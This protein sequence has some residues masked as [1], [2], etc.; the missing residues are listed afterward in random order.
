MNIK[1]FLTNNNISYIPIYYKIENGRKKPLFDKSN[2]TME[3][4]NNIDKKHFNKDG[5]IKAWSIFIK[6]TPDLY[7]IDIDDEYVNNIQD[8]NDVDAPYIDNE[9]YEKIKNTIWIKGNTKGIHIYLYITKMPIFSTY[10]NV[11]DGFKGDLIRT[12]N[13]WEQIDKDVNNDKI[14][15][16][17]FNDIEYLFNDRFY[18]S[19]KKQEKYD[20]EDDEDME[21]IEDDEDDELFEINDNMTLSEKIIIK[22]IENNFF[23]TL[24]GYQD[25]LKVCFI[26]SSEL[27][28]N[29]Y[30]YFNYISK[31]QLDSDKYNEASVKSQ[32]DISLNRNDLKNKL[33]I[34]TLIKMVNSLNNEKLKSE[35]KALRLIENKKIKMQQNNLNFENENDD[36]YLDRIEQI[37][38][39]EDYYKIFKI[40]YFDEFKTYEEKKIYFEIFVCKIEDPLTFYKREIIDNKLFENYI[41]ISN[42]KMTFNNLL[43]KM[44]VKDK[45]K[46]ESFINRWTQDPKM[47]TYKQ[48]IFKPFNGIRRLDI[49]DNPKYFNNTFNGYN[50]LIHYDYDKKNK[51][52]IIKPFK[53]LLMDLVGDNEIS[54]NYLYN[55]LSHII[56]YPEKK[57]PYAII[58]KSKQGAGKNVFI[59]AFKNIIG[60]VHY[61]SSSEIKDF[62]GTHAEGLN[63]KLL[64]NMNEMEG[65]HTMDIE[66]LIKSVITESTRT[67]NQ[68]Y[69]KPIKV[70]NFSRLIIFT[71][72]SNPIKIDVNSGDRRFIIFESTGKYI[73][74]NGTW[75]ERLIEHFNS[76][77]FIAALYDDMNSI[78]LN[79]FSFKERPLT[80]AYFTMTKQNLSTPILFIK[81][82]IEIQ[83]MD[84]Q[85]SSIN[86]LQEFSKIDLYNSYNKYCENYGYRQVQLNENKLFNELK[87][88]NI[89]KIEKSIRGYKYLI[90]FS[91]I[92]EYYKF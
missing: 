53:D 6:H 89:L 75:W 68:K 2:L 13:I 29:G 4:I 12:T 41:P 81:H 58:I 70:D 91:K 64:V 92:N 78:N 79:N 32:W 10:Q 43:F 16:I 7:V 50:P 9:L 77:E 39:D 8:L 25:W 73:K 35:V 24:S 88:L 86:L 11:F 1:R 61:Y 63:K 84:I 3:E 34:G 45:L 26:I 74:K 28:E 20:D 80:E 42:I 56:Q 23:K 71:N 36:N 57:N 72:K 55:Y 62:L 85:G 65:K 18:N 5:Y 44:I 60:D 31:Y 69:I 22:C 66:G 46:N 21:D 27:N 52:E 54:F 40:E 37:K 76:P 49:D 33:S 15:T 67:L 82:L 17:D 47:R 87:D 51:D 38:Q 48:F 14:V 90:D 30:K 19:V 83:E 59:D